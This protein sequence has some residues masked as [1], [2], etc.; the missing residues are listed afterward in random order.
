MPKFNIIEWLRSFSRRRYN[1]D[2]V[3]VVNIYDNGK[4]V[5]RLSRIVTN[6][7]AISFHTQLNIANS[8]VSTLYGE[9]LKAAKKRGWRK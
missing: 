1:K 8:L 6:T 5:C 4:R 9:E 3:I 2:H 7:G